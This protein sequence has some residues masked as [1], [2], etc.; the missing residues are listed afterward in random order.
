[1][2]ASLFTASWQQQ[3]RSKLTRYFEAMRLVAPILSATA[4]PSATSSVSYSSYN[5]SNNSSRFSTPQRDNESGNESG[6]KKVENNNISNS[7]SNKS[8][9]DARPSSPIK[10]SPMS[11]LLVTK[12]SNS[13]P[14][15][16]SSRY[17]SPSSQ[18]QPT[19]GAAGNVIDHPLS[20]IIAS[21]TIQ[22]A[23][24]P[25]RIAHRS[26]SVTPNKSPTNSSRDPHV[27]GTVEIAAESAAKDHR[28]IDASKQVDATSPAGSVASSSPPRR[29]PL[30]RL[31]KR[32]FRLHLCL[33]CTLAAPRPVRSCLG[34]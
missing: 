18:S 31:V 1:M 34:V 8:H 4:A 14:T 17:A 23:I 20:K 25:P 28:A 3:V 9:P 27:S 29:P 6:E 32:T 11:H 15:T 13:R 30:P 5:N 24:P 7:R 16:P 10:F 2:Y 33:P 19:L 21:A 26:P 12:G 22:G